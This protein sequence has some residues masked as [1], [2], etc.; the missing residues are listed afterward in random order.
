M[1]TP[2]WFTQQVSAYFSVNLWIHL[3]GSLSRLQP[4]PRE[5][6]DTSGWFTQQV[7]TY[8]PGNWWIHLDDSLSRF[9]TVS[10]LIGE[11]IWM[12][13]SAGFNLFPRELMNKS[14]HLDGTLSRLQ[15]LF[16]RELVN[17]S[18]WFTQQVSACFQ[19]IGE[20]IWMVHSA[21]F[22]CFQGIGEYIWMVHSAGF[23]LFPGNWWI[24]LDGSLSRFQLISM[25]W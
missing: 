15:H 7:S 19:G 23:H 13:H 17:T 18:G 24:H 10:K 11:Y 8:S 6:V 16:L 1:N 20:Y 3:D 12:V 5:L 4:I 9:Q 22:S 14:G 25:E 21:D 2:G